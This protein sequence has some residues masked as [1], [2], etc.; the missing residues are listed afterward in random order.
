MTSEFETGD[1]V[2][3]HFVEFGGSRWHICKQCYTNI[4]KAGQCRCGNMRL[5]QS[6]VDPNQQMIHFTYEELWLQ[7][8]DN[9]EDRCVPTSALV[10]PSH[11]EQQ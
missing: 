11:A 7:Q 8:L 3:Y 10:A 2:P 9:G 4:Y 1:D 6:P 5:K